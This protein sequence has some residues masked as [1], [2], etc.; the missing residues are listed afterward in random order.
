MYLSEKKQLSIVEN[1]YTKCKQSGSE[2]DPQIRL[3]QDRL[4]KISIE[5]CRLPCDSHVT[6]TQCHAKEKQPQQ[7]FKIPTIEEINLYCRERKNNVDAEKFH[8]YY[9]AIGW[10][11]GKNQ[12]KDWK[13]AVRTWEKSSFDKNQNT[14]KKQP[15]NYRML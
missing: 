9:S 15:M 8:S 3:D 7:K 11:V 6:V 10:K 13:A 2:M 1:S 4:D 5:E 12:M 14:E